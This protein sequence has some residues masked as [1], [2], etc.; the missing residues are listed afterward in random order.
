MVFCC[1][2]RFWILSQMSLYVCPL[3]LSSY[4]NDLFV[5]GFVKSILCVEVLLF[6]LSRW[7]YSPLCWAENFLLLKLH[8][9]KLPL[10]FIHVS[11]EFGM[12]TTIFQN[13]RW[14]HVWCFSFQNVSLST[15]CHKFHLCYVKM[16][17]LE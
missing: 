13:I 5:L 11:V 4:I 3:Q 7:S 16:M 2:S 17:K 6:Y 1:G 8:F 15:F 10:F 12:F 9:P 14:W